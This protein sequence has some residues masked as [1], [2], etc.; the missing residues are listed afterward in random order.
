M[1]RYFSRLLIISIFALLFFSKMLYCQ[2]WAPT[3]AKWYYT[4]SGFAGGGGLLI[5]ESIKDT[6]IESFECKKFQFSDIKQYQAGPDTYYWGTTTTY[7]FFYFNADSINHFDQLNGYF[8]K[9]YDFSINPG[10]TILVRNEEFP[11]VLPYTNFEYIVDSIVSK[12]IQ[13]TPLNFYYVRATDSSDWI[14]APSYQSNYPVIERIGSTISFL[15]ISL[16][17]FSQQLGNY[18]LR[19]YIDENLI[20][21]FTLFPS[22][23]ECDCLPTFIEEITSDKIKLY[24]I[25]VKNYLNISQKDNSKLNIKIFNAQGVIIDQKEV[26]GNSVIDVTHYPPGIFIMNVYINSDLVLN[27]LILK[28]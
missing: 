15:G 17:L 19:C 11:G 16:E 20:Y 22:D 3:G 28:L 23:L 13:S 8:Y 2:E 14:F 5:I 1:I 7:E 10:D 26:I 27:K 21:R 25:P 12:N 6:V 18:Y 24:P 9:L 4:T